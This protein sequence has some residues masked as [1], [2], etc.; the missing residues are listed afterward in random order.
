MN[1]SILYIF[2]EDI[3]IGLVWVRVCQFQKRTKL[4]SATYLVAPECGFCSTVLINRFLTE[5]CT[6]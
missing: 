5:S 2:G 4:I 1:R 3:L 6:T